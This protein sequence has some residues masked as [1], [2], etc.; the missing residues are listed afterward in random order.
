M[1]WDSPWGK[2]F[3]G[4]HIECTAMSVKYLGDKF[5]IHTGGKEHIPVHHTN[6]IAQGYGAFRM[7]TANYW[8]HNDW[9]TLKD[10]KM[11]KSKGNI[12][13]IDE[14]VDKG[15]DP[16]HFRYLVLTSHYKKGLVFSFESLDAAKSAY[17]KLVGF[18]RVWKQG[19]RS[20]LSPDKMR[21]IEDF[22]KIFVEKLSG[23]LNVSEALAVVWGVAK[24]NLPNAD[25]LDLVLDFDRVLGLKL[26]E[27]AENIQN[28]KI[29]KKV[30][31]LISKREEFRKRGDYKKAD[32]VR[33]SIEKSGFVLEDTEKGSIIK[34][35]K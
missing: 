15:Y 32:E 30:V 19:G 27:S 29:P 31:E 13:T 4:W 35:A 14:L 8:L 1:Q 34:P 9:L 25:K 17:S 3:P 12:Y 5:D 26:A 24:S 33:I 22:Q 7:Q 10:E 6:E 23:D 11:S 16:M 28:K 20:A 21:K 18:I 2:G